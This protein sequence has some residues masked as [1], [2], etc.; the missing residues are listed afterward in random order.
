MIE[1][2]NKFRYTTEYQ[3]DLLRFIVRDK[4]GEKA[5]KKIEDDYFTLIEHQVIAHALKNYYK[6]QKRIPGET[7][8]R[9]QIMTLL[10]TKQFINLVTKNEQ[11]EIT[12]LLKPLYSGDLTDGD[13][14][15]EMCKQF[16]T[17]IKV[18]NVIEEVDIN[19]FDSFKSVSR[20][21]QVAI[22]DEDETE[23]LSS[24]FLL[25]DIKNRQLRRQQTSTIFPT[26]F[27]QINDITNGG[28]YEKGSVIV[29]LDKQ[30]KGKTMMLA[31]VA[32][33]YL[34][35]QKKVLVI[36]F[37]NGKD[38]YM[39]RFEQSIMDADKKTIL[40]GD[41]DDK[42]QARFRKYKRLGGEVVILRLPALVTTCNDLQYEIDKLYNEFGFKADIIVLDYAAK[43]G[44]ISRK[45][46]DTS[47]ISDV[48]IEIQNLALKN[49]I[50]HVWTANHVTR[51]G[52]RARM[53]SRYQGEDIA[54][55]IDIV[56]HAQA[57]FGLNRSPEEEQADFL[58]MELVE[59]RDG[60]Q[61]GRAVFK[62]SMGTQR[63]NE[64]KSAERKDFDDIFTEIIQNNGSEEKVITKK[65]RT[66]D[67]GEQ[68]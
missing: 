40:S 4:R 67:F 15:Y 65:K 50:E 62:V 21:F 31:N 26:P 1:N 43:M 3:W 18:K 11:H 27:K 5:L 60:I 64:L 59:Q 2:R 12:S 54:L 36:D 48:Y 14:V 24:S 32:R 57:I 58:R 52:A 20:Q 63:A 55:C 56:R 51:E 28:G 35:M 49:D 41:L 6:K 10:N 22:S 17:Y 45:E 47:R 37:E 46:N 39:T 34:R 29:I 44:S 25:K 16:S 30:K 61:E 42:I 13:E 66:D 8:L 23:D 19:D 53:K 9:E 68:S 7:V 38:N 33:G